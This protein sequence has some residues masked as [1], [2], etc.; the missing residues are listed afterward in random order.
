[1]HASITLAGCSHTV[2]S[3]AEPRLELLQH[4]HGPTGLPIKATD[5]AHSSAFGR[6]IAQRSETES[7]GDIITPRIPATRL[8]CISTPRPI[9]SVSWPVPTICDA[10]ASSQR[11]S[12]PTASR[13]LYAHTYHIHSS[14][15]H[16]SASSVV[17]TAPHRAH[18]SRKP[19]WWSYL[20][21]PALL[22]VDRSPST[23]DALGD[24]VLTANL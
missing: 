7:P 17:P 22:Y 2:R 9:L 3:H 11:W 24:R 15:Q 5:T 23:G 6:Q 14:H 16:V 20:R 21:A 8:G 19:T 12:R 1:M 4:L 18:R 13:H 10:P